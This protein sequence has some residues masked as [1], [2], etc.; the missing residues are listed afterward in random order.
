MDI[1]KNMNTLADEIEAQ[2][3]VD[4]FLRRVSDEM[5]A[6][7]AKWGVQHHPIGNSSEEFKKL[8]D[9]A[10]RATDAAAAN[11]TLTWYEIQREEYY[12]AF[13]EDN[14]AAMVIELIQV[15][16]VAGSIVRDIEVNYRDELRRGLEKLTGTH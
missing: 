10:R 7:I 9:A 3:I 1:V 16:A 15:A 14:L 13:A 11:G 6:Q 5:A 8:A 4:S 2:E 12:E